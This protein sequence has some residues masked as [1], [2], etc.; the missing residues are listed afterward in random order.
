MLPTCNLHPPPAVSA[1][2]RGSRSFLEAELARSL[3]AWGPHESPVQGRR[4]PEAE[5]PWNPGWQEA[6]GAW[7][8]P[9]AINS[10]GLLPRNFVLTSNQQQADRMAAISP[11]LSHSLAHFPQSGGIRGVL[12]VTPQ[13]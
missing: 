4:G 1:Q 8:L 3:K 12:D 9:D 6:G 10:F 13:A 7:L 5:G 2:V 11:A